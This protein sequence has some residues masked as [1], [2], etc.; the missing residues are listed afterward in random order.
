MRGD[1]REITAPL[2]QNKLIGDPNANELAWPTLYQAF[3]L[4]VIMGIFRYSKQVFTWKL[5]RGVKVK[6]PIYGVNY[7]Q[8]YLTI[9][10]TGVLHVK[11]NY[12]WNGC[13]P[14]FEVFGMV[15]GTPEGSLP[16]DHEKQSILNNLENLS[17]KGFDWRMPKTYYASLIHDSLYQI[18]EKCTGQ[19]SREKVDMIF[20]QILRAYNFFLAPLY[21][22]AVKYFGKYYWGGESK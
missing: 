19:M 16:E 3:L 17:Y 18:S 11:R 4:G 10:P 13:S 9:S 8:T 22:Q 21:Y 15:F 14:K 20:Y 6:L 2:T 7:N 1:E 12:A 5:D